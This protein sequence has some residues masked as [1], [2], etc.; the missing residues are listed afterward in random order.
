MQPPKK[1]E[2]TLIQT[3]DYKAIYIDGELFLEGR[4]PV[5]DG[6]TYIVEEL[7]AEV[8]IIQAHKID[9]IWFDT[10]IEFPK[11]LKDVKL[12]SRKW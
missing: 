10:M 4:D 9:D 7:G 12:S 8:Q 1:R 2:I 11:K 6:W 5:G 3:D